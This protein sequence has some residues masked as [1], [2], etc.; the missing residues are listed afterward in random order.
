LFCLVFEVDGEI[1][2]ETAVVDEGGAFEKEGLLLGF[3]E[4][5]GED[6]LADGIDYLAGAGVEDQLAEGCVREL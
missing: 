5:E 3:G 4:V 2:E 6:R 1:V